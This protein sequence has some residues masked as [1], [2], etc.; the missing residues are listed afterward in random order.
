MPMPVNTEHAVE[1]AR[2]FILMKF[3]LQTKKKKTNF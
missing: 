1:N 2:K 3:E